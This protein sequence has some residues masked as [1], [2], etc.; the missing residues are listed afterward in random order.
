MKSMGIAASSL[1]TTVPMD[2]HGYTLA[3]K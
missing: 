3:T 2:G 1:T